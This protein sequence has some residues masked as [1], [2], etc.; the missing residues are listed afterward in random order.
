MTM[1]DAGRPGEARFDPE[2]GSWVLTS[3]A[4]VSA[5]LRDPRLTVLGT[6]GDGEAAHDAVRDAAAKA[7]SPARLA[8]WRGEIEMSARVLIQGLPADLPVDLMEAFVRPWSLS[9]AV[10]AAN[11]PPK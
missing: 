2:L 7:V 5:A 9:L 11:A 8:A 3:Y 1:D 4:D 10:L 6:G